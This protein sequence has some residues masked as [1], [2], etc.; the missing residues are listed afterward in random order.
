LPLPSLPSPMGGH[1]LSSS[2]GRLWTDH[3]TWSCSFKASV[4]KWG[5]VPDPKGWGGGLYE[6]WR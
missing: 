5:L 6:D 1:L 3:S 4:I 2:V